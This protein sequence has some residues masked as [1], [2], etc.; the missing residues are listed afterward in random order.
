[1]VASRRRRFQTNHAPSAET[2][3]QGAD[4][5]LLTDHARIRAR[6]C[7]LFF[8]R[9]RLSNRAAAYDG[10]SSSSPIRRCPGVTCRA[11]VGD[12][13][14][15]EELKG[16]GGWEA[17]LSMHISSVPE[18]RSH[19]Y[20]SAPPSGHGGRTMPASQEF[21]SNTTEVTTSRHYLDVNKL[22][23]DTSEISD[24]ATCHLTQSGTSGFTRLT[25]M[26]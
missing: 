25:L 6:S 17:F 19:T 21:S 7:C 8:R 5:P 20:M 2:I 12:G 9:I 3:I 18:A 11:N 23:I 22:E 13:P 15:S 1:M 26:T 14:P 10:V 4:R 24:P 16:S